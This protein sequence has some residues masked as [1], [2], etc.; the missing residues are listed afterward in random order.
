[1][2]KVIG[3]KIK[4]IVSAIALSA[5]VATFATM[6]V[7]AL[8]ESVLQRETV[9]LDQNR[10]FNPNSYFYGYFETGTSSHGARTG[11]HYNS[12]SL[13]G[14]AYSVLTYTDTSG[15]VHTSTYN[16][17]NSGTG[18]IDSAWVEAPLNYYKSVDK[19]KFVGEKYNIYGD[20]TKRDI[21]YVNY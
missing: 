13:R 20:A 1:M 8:T 16:G 6:A 9:S 3:R 11:T 2:K 17:K 21:V 12:G 10:T 18:W 19:I 15:T 4:K 7:S 14:C 5:V